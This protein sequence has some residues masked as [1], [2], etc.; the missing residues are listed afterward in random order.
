MLACRERRHALGQAGR[1]MAE[2]YG[3]ESVTDAWETLY[4]SVLQG[5]QAE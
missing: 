3:I 4:R 2:G 5:K 1:K